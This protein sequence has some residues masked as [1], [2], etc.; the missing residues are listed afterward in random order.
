MLS[1]FFIPANIQ[2][3]M[4]LP[5]KVQIQVSYAPKNDCNLLHQRM[6]SYGGGKQPLAS[7]VH[8]LTNAGKYQN[9][10]NFCYSSFLVLQCNDLF[11]I[12]LIS[13]LSTPVFYCNSY[14]LMCQMLKLQIEVK[15]IRCW[16]NDNYFDFQ[17]KDQK[18]FEI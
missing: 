5:L 4:I 7:K 18:Y 2:L 14:I 11:I 12:Y 3:G 16:G 6:K 13:S 8:P 10:F 15:G 17:R 9:N 1:L